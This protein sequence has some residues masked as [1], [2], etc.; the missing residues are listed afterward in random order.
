KCRRDC[1][2]LA[3]YLFQ[4]EGRANQRVVSRTHAGISGRDDV[5]FSAKTERA[6]PIGAC[7]EW[8][9]T[10]GR[11]LPGAAKGSQANSGLGRADRGVEAGRFGAVQRNSEDGGGCG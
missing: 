1:G 11:R 10:L 2:S 3:F 8:L 4:D 7:L 5:Q 9:R 6:A